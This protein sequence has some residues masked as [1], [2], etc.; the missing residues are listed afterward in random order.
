MKS[1]GF[2][3]DEGMDETIDINGRKY[4]IKRTADKITL[5]RYNEKHKMQ[6]NLHFPT[7]NQAEGKEIENEILQILANQY[8]ERNIKLLPPIRSIKRDCLKAYKKDVD[9]IDGT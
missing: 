2:V 6:V 9:F 5:C 8:I 3:R 4:K 7:D 1:D